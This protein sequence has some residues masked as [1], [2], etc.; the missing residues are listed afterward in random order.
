VATSVRRPKGGPET[1]R[2]PVNPPLNAIY[3]VLFY[4]WCVGV[5][6]LFFWQVSVQNDGTVM[7][8]SGGDSVVLVSTIPSPFIVADKL[9][10]PAPPRPPRALEPAA[11][12]P[13]R[14]VNP[15]LSRFDS[16]NFCSPHKTALSR[17]NFSGYVGHVTDYRV[18]QIVSHYQVSSLNRIKNKNRH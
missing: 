13:A 9:N 4:M 18:V 7:L 15:T 5:R 8:D 6:R 14:S 10:Q 1:A 3:F 17:V 12:D 16:H 11:T 2:P